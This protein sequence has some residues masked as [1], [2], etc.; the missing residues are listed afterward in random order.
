MITQLNEKTL[1][2]SKIQKFLESGTHPWGMVVNY[3][4]GEAETREQIF[5][6]HRH[7]QTISIKMND[8]YLKDGT[9]IKDDPKET[10]IFEENYNK[11][12]PLI[13]P[14]I[15]K[16]LGKGFKGVVNRVNIVKLKS[17]SMIHRH[18]DSGNSL[19]KSIRVHIPIITN[20]G[21]LF[22]VGEVTT[23]MLEGCAYGINN[24]LP[25]EV[26][27]T[28]GYDRIHLIVDYYKG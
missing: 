7:T 24:Q 17:N 16:V 3:N 1:D 4:K 20:E 13:K 19:E 21:V 2:V 22:R 18:T 6:V 27:N 28:S 25:H 5:D 9:H 10:Y 11:Y 15:D 14:L 12:M 23:N 26:I 8:I